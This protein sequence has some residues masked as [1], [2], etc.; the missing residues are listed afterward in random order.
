M[1]KIEL[2]NKGFK[3]LKI[4]KVIASGQ[5]SIRV[6]MSL[7]MMFSTALDTRNFT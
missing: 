4:M 1:M 5:R 7:W 3:R 6:K 2:C